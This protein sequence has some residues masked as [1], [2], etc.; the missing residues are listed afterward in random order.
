M[1]VFIA[2]IIGDIIW[3]F[4]VLVINDEKTKIMTAV[5]PF[6]PEPKSGAVDHSAKLSCCVQFIRQ[7]MGQ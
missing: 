4:C 2:M 1:R 3:A 6:G 5:G 7:I